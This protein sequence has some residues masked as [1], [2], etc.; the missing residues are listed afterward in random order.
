MLRSLICQIL[1][2]TRT[3]GEPHGGD[4]VK[5]H[6]GHQAPCSGNH[7]SVPIHPLELRT[8]TVPCFH[9]QEK[10]GNHPSWMSAP[11]FIKIHSTFIAIKAVN[12]NMLVVLKE[13]LLGFILCGA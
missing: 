4:G 11:G 6:R 9:L 5:D 13:T 8:K 3:S 7:G 12:L 1:D 10:S 2:L